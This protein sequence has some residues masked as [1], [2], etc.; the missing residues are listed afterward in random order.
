M[1]CLAGSVCRQLPGT[2]CGLCCEV[3]HPG[4]V[5]TDVMRRGQQCVA[6]YTAAGGLTQGFHKGLRSSTY[7]SMGLSLQSERKGPQY[8]ILSN[9]SLRSPDLC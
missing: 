6:P 5:L 7:V 2:M 3:V 1:N 4:S 8:G 9:H